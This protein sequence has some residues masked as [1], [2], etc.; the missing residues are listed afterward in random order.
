MAEPDGDLWENNLWEDSEECE[1]VLDE[2]EYKCE[3]IDVEKFH[4]KTFD[5]TTVNDFKTEALDWVGQME[6]EVAE[7]RR[8]IELIP[9]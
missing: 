5:C 8:L 6:L 9:S 1:N 3:C 4:S 2:L 7:L